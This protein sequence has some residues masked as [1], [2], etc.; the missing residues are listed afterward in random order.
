MDMKGKKVESKHEKA[1]SR[2]AAPA[3]KAAKTQHHPATPVVEAAPTKDFNSPGP[4]IVRA[5]AMT[6]LDAADHF[7]VSSGDE[8]NKA[9]DPA[10]DDLLQ[11]QLEPVGTA[12]AIETVVTEDGALIKTLD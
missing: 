6:E 10:S 11:A 9:K 3:K 1:A 5:N 2:K 4:G 8:F 12:Q 7:D